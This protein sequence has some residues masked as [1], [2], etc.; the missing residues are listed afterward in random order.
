MRRPLEAARYLSIKYTERLAG[1][2]SMVTPDALST[3]SKRLR[4]STGAGRGAASGPSN[5]VTL[6]WVDWFNN[7]RLLKP[8]GN[9]SPALAEARYYALPEAYALVA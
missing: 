4:S 6:E 7:R 1:A 8:L 3:A 9:I 2:D 5:W